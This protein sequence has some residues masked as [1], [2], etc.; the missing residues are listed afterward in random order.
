MRLVR[1]SARLIEK[2]NITVKSLEGDYARL[3]FVLPLLYG[4]RQEILSLQEKLPKNGVHWRNYREILGYLDNREK[5]YDED[6]IVAATFLS[7]FLHSPREEHKEAFAKYC[8]AKL[9]G[10]R[11]RT[12]AFVKE[13][14]GEAAQGELV[15]FET[16][17]G[18]YDNEGLWVLASQRAPERWWSAVA[19]THTE[20][21]LA[22]I[23]SKLTRIP[24]HA[25]NCERTFSD[26]GFLTCA[27]RHNMGPERLQKASALYKR[28]RSPQAESWW[29][30]ES[31]DA[32]KKAKMGPS[33]QDIDFSGVM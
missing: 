4:I 12:M 15:E 19:R 11:A 32:K 5:K 9:T 22:A 26:M 1:Y 16:R 20:C 25:C 6:F 10:L 3:G 7:P 17:T 2:V 14:I 21:R 33:P 31:A 13:R 18:L 28:L 8:T 23:G 27:N 29:E 24:P 30:A